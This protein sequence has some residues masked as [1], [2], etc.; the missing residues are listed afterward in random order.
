MRHERPL[1]FTDS[2]YFP[3]NLRSSSSQR[4]KAGRVRLVESR[5]PYPNSQESESHPVHLHREMATTSAASEAQGAA[6]AS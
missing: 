4:M 5:A 3:S 1:G 2:T 6:F